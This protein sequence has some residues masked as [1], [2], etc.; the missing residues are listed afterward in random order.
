MRVYMFKLFTGDYLA[1]IKFNDEHIRESPFKLYIAPSSDR[2]KK[3]QVPHHSGHQVCSQTIVTFIA[4]FFHSN[5][6]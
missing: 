6:Y 1:S 3:Q 2:N 4:E 5:N